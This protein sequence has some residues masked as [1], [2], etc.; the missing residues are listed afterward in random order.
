MLK[1]ERQEH[2]LRE[3]NIHNKVLCSDLSIKLSV[4]EDTIRRDLNELAEQ[5]KVI[6]VHGGALSRSY[7]TSAY[8]QAEVYALQEKTIIAGK[9]VTL[10]QEG[11]LVFVSGGTTNRELARILPPSLSA[12][13][14][15]PSL[16]TAIQ[17]MEHPSSEVIL[18][19]GKVSRNAGISVGGEVISRL[20]EVRA[21][22]C[23]LGTN[24]IDAEEGITDSDWEV[25]QVKKAMI[26]RA[27]KVAAL[28]L[29]EKLDSVQ[30]MKVCDIRQVNY[31]ITELE[32]QDKRLIPYLKKGVEVF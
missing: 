23:I 11:M 24:S 32:A 5:D 17:L 25:V 10:L 16:S 6:K 19:G 7:H 13:F 18:L 12:T 30:R 3:V 31:L 8:R 29:A 15:T 4:S 26:N 9:A 21:D 1:S 28:A 22:L 27:D 20:N 14:F 2:I